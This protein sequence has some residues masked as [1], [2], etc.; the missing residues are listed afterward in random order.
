MRWGFCLWA[1]ALG[2]IGCEAV[3]SGK[4]SASGDPNKIVL[5]STLG[6]PRLEITASFAVG[7]DPHPHIQP[8]AAALAGARAACFS[9]DA[10]GK[11]GSVAIELDV[12]DQHVH[13]EARNPAGEC[14]AHAI[15]GK[16]IDDR[17]TYTVTLLIAVG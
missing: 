8:I 1:C 17:A 4:Q 11:P 7:F 13:A 14:M 5:E 9:K 16:P 3:G 15:D 10:P 2:A 6:L 12:R